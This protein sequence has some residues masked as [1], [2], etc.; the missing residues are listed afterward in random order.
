MT[1]FPYC[2]EHQRKYIHLD[3]KEVLQKLQLLQSRLGAIVLKKGGVDNEGDK[4][5]K[6]SNMFILRD[7][8]KNN[9]P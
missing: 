6:T 1:T 7:W 8:D 5:E 3:L 9:I 4:N 2:F